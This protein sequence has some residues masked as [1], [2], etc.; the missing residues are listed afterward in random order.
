MQV[1]K[2]FYERIAHHES[3]V[4]AILFIL[5]REEGAFGVELTIED[6]KRLLQDLTIQIPIAAGEDA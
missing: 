3:G 6:A 5:R 4:G 1:H 2:F